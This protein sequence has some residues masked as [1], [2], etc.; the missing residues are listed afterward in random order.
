VGTELEKLRGKEG[1]QARA[2]VFFC[3]GSCAVGKFIV[4]RAG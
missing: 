4:G 1:E 3:R 2:F